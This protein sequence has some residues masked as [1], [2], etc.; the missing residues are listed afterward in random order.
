M[1]RLDVPIQYNLYTVKY[2]ISIASLNK[3][4]CDTILGYK[5]FP[6]PKT[7]TPNPLTLNPNPNPN[8]NPKPLTLNPKH[9]NPGPKHTLKL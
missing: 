5:N 2:I 3:L 4:V 7:L 6:N 1:P 8:T 9:P